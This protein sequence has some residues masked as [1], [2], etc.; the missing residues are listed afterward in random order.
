MEQWQIRCCFAGGISAGRH[1]NL[2][3]WCVLILGPAHALPSREKIILPWVIKLW[4]EQTPQSPR[5]ALSLLWALQVLWQFNWSS[6]QVSQQPKELSADC[7]VRLI[8]KR[9][10]S[11]ITTFILKKYCSYF[12]SFNHYN[13]LIDWHKW[14]IQRNECSET[15]PHYALLFHYCSRT[16]LIFFIVSWALHNLMFLSSLRE[17]GI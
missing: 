15:I 4:W 8:Q 7:L 10:K 16:W 3:I 9:S 6:Q 13:N 5:K 11:Q 1:S 2:L 17:D 12:Y 14:A